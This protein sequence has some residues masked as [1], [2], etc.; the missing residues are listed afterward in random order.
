MLSVSTQIAREDSLSTFEEMLKSISFANEIIIFNMQRNDQEFRNIANKFHAKII[1]VKTPK[2]VEVIREDQVSSASGNWVLV[3]DFDEIITPVLS[4]E[5]LKITKEN[6]SAY[7]GFNIL[8]RNYSLGFPLSHGGFGDDYVLRLIHKSSFLSWPTNIHST[9]TFK[10]KVGKLKN[11]MEHH[12]DE[13]VEQMVDKTNRYSDIESQQFLEGSLPKVVTA[14][15]M[16]KWWM[17]TLRRGAF[18][19]G[20]LDGKIGLIQSIYQGFSVFIS[21]AKLYEKQISSKT[22]KS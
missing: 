2:I 18:K 1:E 14:T 10:G 17:E 11:Y 16:R 13:S 21:Y 19:A 20:F 15:L 6:N 5:I 9:P 8:R 3:M 7:S 4:T 12:K 22:T